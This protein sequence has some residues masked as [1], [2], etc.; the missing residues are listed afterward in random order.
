MSTSFYVVYEDLP[1][2]AVIEKVLQQHPRNFSIVGKFCKDGS[3][4]IKK[5]INGF[6][7]SAKGF[8]FLII[9]DLDT[10]ECVPILINS[11]FSTQIHPNL[12]FCVAIREI[13]A[14]ILSD[15]RSFSS[16][17]GVNINKIPLET[18]LLSDPKQTVLNLIRKSSKVRIK[19]DMLPVGKSKVGRLYNDR[20]VEFILKEWNIHNAKNNSMSLYRFYQKLSNYNFVKS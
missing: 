3:G 4:Y 8:P 6:N 2:L 14:W 16:Y 19:N 20:L 11:W 12:L 15:R 9:T 17:F 5:N 13:E 10:I 7:Q 1:S 18:E